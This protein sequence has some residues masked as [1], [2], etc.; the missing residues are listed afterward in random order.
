[1][2][3]GSSKH[4]LKRLLKIVLGVI[5]AAV[6]ITSCSSPESIQNRKVDTPQISTYTIVPT[7][8]ASPTLSPAVTVKG[9]ATVKPTATIKATT[10]IKATVKPTTSSK[11]TSTSSKAT[12]KIKASTSIK[13]TTVYIT[14]TGKKYHT[15]GCGYLSRSKHAISLKDAKARGYTPCSRCHPPK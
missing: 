1:M 8:T 4:F 13:S 2:K 3:K 14:D 10:K 5:V 11:T 12:S 9:T 6:I 15:S 7:V